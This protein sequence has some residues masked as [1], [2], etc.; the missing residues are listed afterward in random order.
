MPAG[1]RPPTFSFRGPTEPTVPSWTRR[2][3]L[4]RQAIDLRAAGAPPTPH[5]LLHHDFH[6]GNILWHNDTITGLVDWTE[7]SWGPADPDVAHICSDIAMLHTTA[8]VETFRGQ[9]VEQGGK[10]DPDADA[11]RFWVVNDILGF[12]PDPAHI[13][14]AVAGNRPDLTTGSIRRGLED[15]LALTLA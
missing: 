14:P 3:A 8:D 10:L 6:F 15:L 1:R 4:W 7:T 11:S 9:Y 13:L 2:P 5:G 12:L